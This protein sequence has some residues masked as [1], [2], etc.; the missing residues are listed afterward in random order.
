[1]AIY[2]SYNADIFLK[3]IQQTILLPVTVKTVGLTGLFKL[4]NGNQSERKKTL[5]S[6]LLYPL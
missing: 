4:R 6:N 2:I 3:A 5:N 1:M